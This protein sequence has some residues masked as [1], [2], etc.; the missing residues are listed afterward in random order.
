MVV[1][2]QPCVPAVFTSRKYSWYSFLLEA[3]RPQGHSAIGWILC[4][5]KIQW[6]QLGSNQRPSELWHSTLTTVLPRSPLAPCVCSYELGWEK[7][8]WLFSVLHSPGFV[9][10]TL[11]L[12]KPPS[13]DEWH[14]LILC[15]MV[16][17][18]L[19]S[20]NVF[21]A[22]KSVCILLK[23]HS[24]TNL[25]LFGVISSHNFITST[26]YVFGTKQEFCT[27]NQFWQL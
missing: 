14:T 4:R 16:W 12:V 19:K 7:N 21:Y 23:I 18:S 22:P 13:F 2:C 1:S 11:S 15:F 8:G 6:H 10:V 25:Y 26:S 20:L 27:E 3:G 17:D 24:H 9:Q 5:W